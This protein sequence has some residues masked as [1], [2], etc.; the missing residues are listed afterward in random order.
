M[1][2]VQHYEAAAGHHDSGSFGHDEVHEGLKDREYVVV[3]LVL[4]AITAVEVGLTYATA[5]PHWFF[6][7]SLLTLMTV[8]FFTV[9]L[10]FMHVRYDAK[11]FGRLFYIGLGLA[12]FVYMVA[13]F[14]F[15]FFSS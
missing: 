5:L 6:M 2:E 13:L 11:I 7:L 1:T 14:T 3:A 12:V 9:V 4:A 10:F 15:H 8:K